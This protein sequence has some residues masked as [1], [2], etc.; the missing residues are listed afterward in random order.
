MLENMAFETLFFQNVIL[1]FHNGHYIQ[2]SRISPL[3]KIQRFIRKS[4]DDRCL[5]HKCDI[6]AFLKYY[7]LVSLLTTVVELI[8]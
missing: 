5:L 4:L 3:V 2:F 8:Y 7:Y 1:F 6:A